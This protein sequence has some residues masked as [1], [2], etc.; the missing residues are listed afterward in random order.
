MVDIMIE[1]SNRTTHKKT[2]STF[3]FVFQSF[4]RKK[5]TAQVAMEIWTNIEIKTF[6]KNKN[7]QRKKPNIQFEIESKQ[8]ES[9]PDVRHQWFSSVKSRLKKSWC[10]SFVC[11]FFLCS[12]HLSVGFLVNVSS[13]MWFQTHFPCF[14][15]YFRLLMQYI[16]ISKQ[17]KL[18]TKAYSWNIFQ[19]FYSNESTNCKAIQSCHVLRF[20]IEVCCQCAQNTYVHSISIAI[21]Y[22]KPILPLDEKKRKVLN[23]LCLG[24]L[25]MMK[26]FE[27]SSLLFTFCVQKCRC[28]FAWFNLMLLFL[29]KGFKEKKKKEEESIMDF[30]FV[31]CFLK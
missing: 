31:F 12:S 24:F 20:V 7:R 16:S 15:R 6:N 28:L 4:E 2:P 1:I 9:I 30:G 29:N 23:C 5:A 13:S 14:H 10:V 25:F 11:L 19:L 3:F 18:W 8:L 22:R 21:W 26:F 17:M 27:S